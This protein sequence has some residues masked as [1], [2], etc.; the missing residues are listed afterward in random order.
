MR[1]GDDEVGRETATATRRLARGASMTF[2]AQFADVEVDI[3]TGQMLYVM[4]IEGNEL[5]SIFG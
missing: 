4:K 2:A 1:A 5:Y 3:E